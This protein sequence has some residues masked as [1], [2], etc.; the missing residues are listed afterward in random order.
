MKN[1]LLVD[2]DPSA[3]EVLAESLAR[4]GFKVHTASS[5]HAAADLFTKEPADLLITDVILSDGIGYD[6][7]SELRRAGT[8]KD[9]PVV[10][11]SG[12]HK[13]EGE[14][15][16]AKKNYGALDFLIKPFPVDGLVRRLQDHFG[17]SAVAPQ[18]PQV[19]ERLKGKKIQGELRP[20]T[21]SKLFCH[22]HRSKATGVLQLHHD[23]HARKLFFVSGLPVYASSDIP[24]ETLGRHLLGIGLIGFAD[25]ER[26]IEV[27][28]T[29]AKRA[30][31][32]FIELNFIKR[33]DLYKTIRYHLREKILAAFSWSRGNYEFEFTSDFAP[34]V[35]YYDYNVYDLFLSGVRRFYAPELLAAEL[36][37]LYNLP[38]GP[39]VVGR[40][41]KGRI[42]LSSVEQRVFDQFDGK[43]SL[44]EIMGKDESAGSVAL[45]LLYTFLLL[46]ALE[47]HSPGKAPPEK[48]PEET[49]VDLAAKT[50][51]ATITVQEKQLATL[52]T[53]AA[54][55]ATPIPGLAEYLAQQAREAPAVS[56][57][58]PQGEGAKGARDPRAVQ[59]SIR[60]HDEWLH[61]QTADE[62]AVLGIF[63]GAGDDEIASA[64]KAKL[65]RMTAPNGVEARLSAATQERLKAIRNR[66]QRASE[67]L[68]DPERRKFLETQR[69]DR[70]SQAL[71]KAE[72]AFTKGKNLL[73]QGRLGAA[74]EAF[75]LALAHIPDDADSYAYLAYTIYRA[76][77][78]EGGAAR[79]A[80][81]DMLEGLLRR[82]PDCAAAHYLLARISFEA[83]E[84]LTAQ[85]HLGEAL[86]QSPSHSDALTLQLEIEKLG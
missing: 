18:V 78:A 43:H 22:F 25:Y 79:Q 75:R 12:V 77:S 73:E 34:T 42:P 54:H 10:F 16:F 82:R 70:E 33:D 13:S 48:K 58:V 15:D 11:L 85:R 49:V 6:L 29:T 66:I 39:S 62:F 84:V 80:A 37:K 81:G 23:G 14:R 31:E 32:V 52:E 30:G 50:G 38:V 65:A 53:P 45:P 44:S 26:A 46:G 63:P 19:D 86:R 5:A 68:R 36:A 71:Y 47:V 51:A 7:V 35:E 57:E 59:F 41:A 69:K 64:K 2:D 61:Q 20:T 27:Q 8:A 9:L 55:A 83:G 67:D 1:I 21:F 76:R 28:R 56:A 24:T 72:L 40:E 60:V 17:L 3:R 74:E 4:R